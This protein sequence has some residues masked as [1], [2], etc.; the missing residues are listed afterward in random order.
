[1]SIFTSLSESNIRNNYGYL[2]QFVEIVIFLSDAV[3]R[4]HRIVT[5]DLRISF[6]LLY[7]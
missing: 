7:V 4:Q 5:A 3:G 6:S 1:M 2:L